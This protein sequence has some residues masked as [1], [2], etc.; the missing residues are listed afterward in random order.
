[1]TINSHL[2]S[3]GMA[4]A[5]TRRALKATHSA[6]SSMRSQTAEAREGK[7]LAFHF[8]MMNKYEFLAPGINLVRT[9][10][11]LLR[12]FPKVLHMKWIV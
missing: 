4:Q 10:S 3:E 2:A 1:M 5:D 11:A 12:L 6:E 7:I 8:A 9:S